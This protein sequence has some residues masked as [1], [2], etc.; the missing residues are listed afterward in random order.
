MAEL[1][2]FTVDTA[3]TPAG[4]LPRHPLDMAAL[5]QVAVPPQHRIRADQQPEPTQ[6]RTGEGHEQGC[7]QRPVL[8]L[9]PCTLISELPAQDCELMAQSENLDVL[10]TISH[11]REPQRGT[12]VGDGPTGEPDQHGRDRAG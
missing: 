4:V 5:H 11:A 7:E 12:G 3:V 6:R 1:E 9:Q 2:Q 8:R 10:L